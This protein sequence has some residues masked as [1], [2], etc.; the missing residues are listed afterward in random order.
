MPVPLVAVIAFQQI[1]PFHLSV[2][3]LVFGESAPENPA[4]D[5]RVC[6]CEDGPLITSA[7]FRI[8]VAHGLELLQRAQIII[9]PSWRD[10]YERPPQP[11][12]DALI[13]AHARGAQLLGLCLGAFVLAET[14]LLD[15]GRATTHWAWSE[16]FSRRFPLVRLD[17]DVLYIDEGR[18]LTS[19]GTS[20]GLDCCLHLVRQLQGSAFANQVARKLVMAPHRQG[21]Q[22][23]FIQQPLPASLRDSRLGE[24]LDW[25][26]GNLQLAHTVDS[27]AQKALMSRR[28]FTRHF[29]LL[30]GT[31]VHHYLLNERLALCQRLLESSKLGMEQIALQ[32]GFGSPVTLRQQFGKAFGVSPSSWRK[33]FQG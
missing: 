22:A 16:V 1:S 5:L 21:G 2:P 29:R 4:F 10:P 26:R 17:P 27:L 30:T 3:C 32:C 14:G 12:L 8:E 15:H 20:A 28:T 9:V 19:A 6:A 23:Q 13:A 24:L 18:I 31:T 33:T 25:V 7:G 11:L